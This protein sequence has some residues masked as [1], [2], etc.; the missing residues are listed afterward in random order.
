MCSI[1]SLNVKISTASGGY[2]PWTPNRG[3]APAP[4]RAPAAPLTS[5]DIFSV[6]YFFYSKLGSLYYMKKWGMIHAD[7][8][9]FLTYSRSLNKL[10]IH[11]LWGRNWKLGMQIQIEYRTN[12]KGFARNPWCSLILWSHVA[13]PPPPSPP[14]RGVRENTSPG[15]EGKI[16]AQGESI[17]LQ[18]ITYVYGMSWWVLSSLACWEQWIEGG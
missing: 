3:A 12:I 13:V 5:A 16:K 11:F 6:L 14:N 4:R 1:A 2:A 7:Y 8:P 10:H 18:P 9:L 17:G 15:F